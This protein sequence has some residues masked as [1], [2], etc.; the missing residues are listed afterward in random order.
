MED[1]SQFKFGS[2]TPFAEPA[3]CVPPYRRRRRPP[4]VGSLHYC[5]FKTRGSVRK[6]GPSNNPRWPCR[7]R[8]LPIYQQHRHNRRGPHLKWAVH[9]ETPPV[10]GRP[11]W[12]GC[13]RRCESRARTHG[14]TTSVQPGVPNDPLP[15]AFLPLPTPTSTRCHPHRR[16]DSR[17]ASP[18]YNEHHIVS[19]RDTIEPGLKYASG[20]GA[21]A[22]LPAV[23][24]T[25][26][27]ANVPRPS[28]LRRPALSLF[29]PPS[30]P[31]RTGR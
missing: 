20:R 24:A 18:Y 16:Y 7:Q 17:N 3:W 30:H 26:I 12:R 10:L 6:S 25:S 13:C 22:L 9:R 4:A 27:V 2:P 11:S 5:I 1:I 29:G 15:P 28:P 19:A 31:R 21:G 14:S 23:R 8:G